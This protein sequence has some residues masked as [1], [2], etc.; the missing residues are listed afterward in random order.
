MAT[1]VIFQVSLKEE[2]SLKMEENLFEVSYLETTVYIVSN[3]VEDVLNQSSI[4]IYLFT[5]N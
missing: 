3:S 2:G 5:L 1:N 4:F